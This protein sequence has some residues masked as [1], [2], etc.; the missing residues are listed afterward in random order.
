MMGAWIMASLLLFGAAGLVLYAMWK[1]LEEDRETTPT[2]C[3]H[4]P[5][6]AEAGGIVER[7]ARATPPVGSGPA[8][9]RIDDLG[10][11]LIVNG[12]TVR[13]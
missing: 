13:R 5:S 2:C 7:G 9:P 3:G 12:R 4:R 8:P 11:R 6:A 10:W 1:V